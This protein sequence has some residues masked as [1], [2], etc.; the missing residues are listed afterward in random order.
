M[1]LIRGAYIGSETIDPNQG[2]YTIYVYCN[3]MTPRPIGDV[4]AAL[5]RAI[6]MEQK[7]CMLEGM[8]HVCQHID[9][10]ADTGKPVQFER[11]KVEVSK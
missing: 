4:L 9:I 10:K 5:L 8:S 2:F 11:G 1:D 7:K 6:P 3:L